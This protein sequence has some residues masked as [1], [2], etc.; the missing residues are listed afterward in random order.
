MRKKE[1]AMD[2]MESFAMKVDN[3][4]TS[5]LRQIDTFDYEPVKRKVGRDHGLPSAKLT[6]GVENLKRYY[7]VALLDPLNL[8]AV[9]KAVD[10]FWHSHILFT[11]EYENFCQ[12]IFGQFIHHEPLD[13]TD[14][15]KVEF[16]RKLYDHTLATYKKLFKSL[17][18]EWWPPSGADAFGPVCL[19]QAVQNA[20]IRAL[21]LF[22]RLAEV[23]GR[24]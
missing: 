8:H 4:H 13:P 20:E 5:K 11:S 19:H 6:A 15:P 21:A 2:F 9:S 10:P 17:D 14:G 18:P 16:V 7:A 22:P 3:Y 24:P 12:F 1:V 23:G